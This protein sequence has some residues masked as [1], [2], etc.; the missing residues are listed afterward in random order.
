MAL[1]DILPRSGDKGGDT[2]ELRLEPVIEG[3]P[4]P[5]AAGAIFGYRCC[6]KGEWYDCDKY[7]NITDGRYKGR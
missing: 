4:Y 5:K 7:G 1:L 3:H 6:I 2:V